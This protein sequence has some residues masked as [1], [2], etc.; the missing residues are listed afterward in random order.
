M[1]IL[2]SYD[3]EPV[4]VRLLWESQCFTC[5]FKKKNS[6]SV[7]LCIFSSILFIQHRLGMDACAFSMLAQ[8]HKYLCI[9]NYFYLFKKRSLCEIYIL[10]NKH[11]IVSSSFVFFC[12]VFFF[13]FIFFY[14]KWKGY[15][16]LLWCCLP[17]L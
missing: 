6:A 13:Y 1:K 16:F 7:V 5:L 2:F 15:L 17:N 11:Y 9:I 3:Y 4:T 12:F 14:G 10:Q 8:Q